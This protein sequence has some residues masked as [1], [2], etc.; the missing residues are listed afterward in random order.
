LLR[1]IVSDGLLRPPSAG[2]PACHRVAVFEFAA[3]C[4]RGPVFP[5]IRVTHVLSQTDVVRW[6]AKLI[7]QGAAGRLPSAKLQDLGLTPKQVVCVSADE[8]AIDA[9]AKL[10]QTHLPAAAV[11]NATGAVVASLH[12]ALLNGINADKLGVLAL[13]VG[14][15]LALRHGTVWGSAPGRPPSPGGG[16]LSRRDELMQRHA[17]ISVGP[18]ATLGTVVDLLATRHARAVFVV[19]DA[20]KPI[21][22]VTPT[23]V[24][25]VVTEEHGPTVGDVTLPPP[26][27]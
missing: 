15:F 20:H 13:P 27:Q 5:P 1:E 18:D 9:Y 26:Q 17:L 24:L 8:P 2:I 10:L 23:D 6:L 22:V 11:V 7:D 19:D 21:S 16:G 25:R 12:L 14:E 4:G 3:P